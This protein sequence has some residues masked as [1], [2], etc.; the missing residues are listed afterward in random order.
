M[1]NAFNLPFG[2]ILI[3]ALGFFAQM[4]FFTRSFIQWF[5]SEKA[6]KVLSPLLFWQISLIAS[7]LMMVYGILR[8]DPAIIMGQFITFYIYIRNLQIQGEWKKIS[9]LFRYPVSL[10]PIACLIW[11]IFSGNNGWEQIIGNEK[12]APWLMV[13]GITAQ[14][15]F[16]FRFVYQWIVAE[17]SKK[18][19]LPV[20]FWYFS[21]AGGILTLTYAILRLDPVLFVSNTLGIFMYSRNL[22]VHYTGKGIF[23]LLP[24]TG[25]NSRFQKSK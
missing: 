5:S 4:L 7:F 13:F 19:T 3:F 24:L 2:S 6:G 17:K 9:G 8:K 18:S 1:N 16:T 21:L 15:T 11:I 23:E 14:V 20:G 10:M 12:I 25:I 22:I